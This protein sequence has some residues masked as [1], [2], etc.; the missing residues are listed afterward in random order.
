[1]GQVKDTQWVGLPGVTRFSNFFV[2]NEMEDR[3]RIGPNL[4]YEYGKA[5]HP[6][7]ENPAGGAQ[8]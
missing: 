2:I 8:P 4:A 7:P 5:V 1:M 3:G 6:Q